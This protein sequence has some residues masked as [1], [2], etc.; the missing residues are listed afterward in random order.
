MTSP[1]GRRVRVQTVAASVV[2]VIDDIVE[3][4]EDTVREPVLSHEL[5]D[6]S[7]PLSSGARGGSGMSEILL[8]TLRTLLPCQPA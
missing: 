3:G 8:G 7:W 1:L 4:F 2:A 6:F 5:P